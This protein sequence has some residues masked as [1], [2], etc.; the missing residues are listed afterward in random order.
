MT[1]LPEIADAADRE[2]RCAWSSNADGE[3]LAGTAPTD[4]DWLFIEYAGSWGS[5]AVAESR[6]PAEVREHLAGRSERV[7]LVRH[8]GRDDRPAGS[9][10]R[11][12]AAR[13]GVEPE[14]SWVRTAVLDDPSELIGLD[15][16][17][18]TA[19]DGPLW[20]VC[21]NG[22]RD[23]CCAEQGRPV[24][25]ALAA[26][27]PHETWETTHLGGHRFAATL[28]ALPTGLTLG[29]V[30][31]DSAVKACQ[32]IAAGSVPGLLTRGHAGR[33]A[34]VQY[35]ELHLRAQFGYRDVRATHSTEGANTITVTIQADDDHWTVEVEISPGEPRQ[36]SCADLTLK[37]APVHR[38]LSA[39]LLNP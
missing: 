38:V 24:A 9:P 39:R 14:E 30:D 33:P 3:V 17:T 4:T 8:H 6:L 31:P 16:A 19:Y 18:M 25:A 34:V 13:L 10:T 22:S 29:R 26:Q 35:A 21:T 12:F 11:V 37:A 28:L 15:P 2:F 7:Q 5:K 23:R 27:W 1:S 20:M 36:A 32:E